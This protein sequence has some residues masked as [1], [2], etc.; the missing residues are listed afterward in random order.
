MSRTAHIHRT[1]GETDVELSLGARR[2][3][4]GRA[5]D[6]RR[7][8]RPPARRGGPPRR[9]RPGRAGARATSRPAPHHTVEDTGIALGQALDEALGD[10]AGIRRF[11]HAVVPMDEARAAARSTSPA[12]RSLLFEGDLRRR[13]RGR[14]RHRPRRGVLPRRREHGQAHAARAGRGGHQRRTTW[15]RRRSRRSRARCGPRWSDDRAWAAC[16]RPRACCDA[17]SRSSTTGWATCA[18]SRRRSSTWA[19]EPVLTSD[20]GPRARGRRRSC[21]PGSGAM[22]KAM[23][24]VRALGLDELLRERV[25]A[26]VPV[27]GLCMGMQLLFEST[28]ELGG[29]EGI[30]LLR[31][32]VEALDAPGLKVPQIGWNPVSWRRASPLNEGLPDPCAFY[33]AQLVRSASGATADVLGTAEYGSEFVSVVARPP[34]YGA[35]VHPEKS[36]PDGLRLLANFVSLRNR[37]SHDPPAGG[38]HPRRQGRAAAP[39]RTSTRRPSTRT[40][41]S[42]P[43]A[44]SWRR[45][46]ASCTSWTSTARARASRPTCEHLERITARAGRAGA[47]R[48]RPALDRL[49]PAGAGGR[50]RARWC[51]A[52]RPSPTR[53]CSTRRWRP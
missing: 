47:V 30:G 34:V 49:D 21:C 24:R 15:S 8:L 43:R 3:G 31:G 12:G 53:T 22:P 25:E 42:R 2:H 10:R 41:R 44:R 5:R 28:T 7:L 45:A 1:T 51:S 9:P 32:P 17:R 23:E 26:G 13:A 50:G 20:H 40:T 35:A 18:R 27:I 19:R 29:A 14:L 46:R 36:G 37:R 38:G 52:P 39:G 11:G 48:R 33:H 16:P 6:G 4:R